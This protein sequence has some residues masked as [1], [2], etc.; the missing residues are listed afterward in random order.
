VIHRALE[1]A[2]VAADGVEA[3]YLT[4][5]G[6]PRHD[7]CELDL[8]ARALPAG[9]ARLT[10]LTPLVGEHAGLGALRAAAAALA[11]AGSPVPTLPDLAE[12]IRGDL[13]FVTNPAKSRSDGAPRTALVHGLARGGGHVALVLRPWHE[14]RGAAA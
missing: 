12:P 11:V 6:H 8:V 4:G 10:A 7:A 3:V 9:R 14:R 13:R 1:V 2:G 5:S